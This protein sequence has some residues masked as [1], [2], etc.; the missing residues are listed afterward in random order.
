[1]NNV[2]VTGSNG[3]IG[4]WLVNKLV[5]RGMTVY[6]VLKDI[7]SDTS[8]IVKSD[9]VNYIY[10]NL[11]N[12]GELYKNFDGIKIDTTYHL[13]WDGVG[14]AKRS[15]YHLQLKNVQAACDCMNSVAKL[16]CK[17]FLCAGTISEKIAENI[18]NID[19][20]AENNIYAISK[21]TTHS[22]L[23]VL[24]RKLNI[25]LVWMQLANAYGPFNTSGN[26][27][28]YILDEFKKG[29][30]PGF[31]KADQP[32]DLIYIE[33]MVEA[34][35]LLG[36]CNVSKDTYYIGSE[37]TKPLK[38]FI[39]RIRDIYPEQ[40]EVKFGVKPDDGLIYDEEWFDICDLVNDTKY[41]QKFSLEKG[42][43]KTIE[44]R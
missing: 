2:L 19:T 32:Y 25:Q 29:N 24:S 35:Y 31:T 21:I 18:L 30:T 13:A 26:I 20:A 28:N 39:L 16:G 33:D 11:E 7:E 44:A 43:L 27:V 10:C 12:I 34:M 3:F 5:D 37:E 9:L 4:S 42:I 17:K 15:D 38:E 22:M 40:V 41:K 23:K 6:A 36:E 14:G 8:T 1:M